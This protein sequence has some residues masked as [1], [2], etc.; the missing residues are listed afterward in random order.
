MTRRAEAAARLAQSGYALL[1]QAR[2]TA[3][4]CTRVGWNENGDH[5]VRIVDKG[6]GRTQDYQVERASKPIGNSLSLA[7]K[8]SK[9]PR[10]PQVGMEVFP[11]QGRLSLL[12]RQK[13]WFCIWSITC[14]GRPCGGPNW[15]PCEGRPAVRGI[16][17]YR[18]CKTI[19]RGCR[20][21]ASVS[22]PRDGAR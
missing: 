22:A 5:Q 2:P 11:S 1:P 7:L 16:A 14:R 20:S 3:P 17:C 15:R 8:L 10:P 6:P 12:G 13:D 9:R 4:P 19:H 18:D 21:L